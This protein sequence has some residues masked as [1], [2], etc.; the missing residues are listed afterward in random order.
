MIDLLGAEFTGDNGP[1]L[2][3]GL[4]ELHAVLLEDRVAAYTRLCKAREQYRHPKDKEYTDFD[5]KTMLD[6]HT[7]DIQAEYELAAG[8]ENIVAERIAVIKL[9][10]EQK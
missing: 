9:I 10:M 1:E 3:L 2:L 7:A 8:Q 6:A 5:R 4:V